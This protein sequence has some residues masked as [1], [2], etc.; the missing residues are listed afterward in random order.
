MGLLNYQLFRYSSPLFFLKDTTL[1]TNS[2][3]IFKKLSQ[4]G[5]NTVFLTDLK[6]HEKNLYYLQRF[7]VTTISLVPYNLNP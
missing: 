6:Y 4:R 2:T 3:L 1:G 5:L 7:N